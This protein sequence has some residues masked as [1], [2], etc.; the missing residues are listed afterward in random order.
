RA[1]LPDMVRYLEGELG[2]RESAITPA[3]ERTQQQITNVSGHTMGMNWFISTANGHTILTHEGGTGG[4]YS[5][6]S[7]ARA[8][9]VGGSV[10]PNAFAVDR[11]MTSS[12]LLACITGRSLGLSP[13]RTRPA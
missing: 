11:L 9:S 10:I 7:S 6:T 5:I 4:Y 2:I 12:N 8:R 13:F 3:L 1:T